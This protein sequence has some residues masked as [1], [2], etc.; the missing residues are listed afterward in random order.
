MK[1]ENQGHEQIWA[2]RNLGEK[3]TKYR[4]EFS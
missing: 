4:N 3:I 1:N 2:D